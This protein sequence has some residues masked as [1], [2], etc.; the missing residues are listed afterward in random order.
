MPENNQASEHGE[1]EA[2]ESRTGQAEAERVSGWRELYTTEDYWEIWLGL[3][4][5]AAGLLIFLSRPPEG[6]EETIDRSNATMAREADEASFRT[7]AWYKASEAKKK[8]KGTSGDLAKSIKSFI[9]KPHG[10]KSNPLESLVVNDELAAQKK[11]A[12]QKKHDAACRAK[13]E[14]LTLAVGL[15][16]VFTSIMMIVMPAFIKLVSVPEVLG[17]A[18]MGGTIDATGAVAAAGE[19]LGE[20]GGSCRCVQR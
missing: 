8:L 7:V 9:S 18:W 4:I 20:R 15:S 12:A 16:L 6:M 11:A 2:E 14:E 5:I 19:F 1:A 17:G 3:A 13:K 10:W